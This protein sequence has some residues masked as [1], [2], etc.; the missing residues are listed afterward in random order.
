MKSLVFRD[1]LRILDTEVNS[2][3]KMYG[4]GERTRDKFFLDEGTYTSWAKDSENKYDEGVAGGNSYGVHPVYF[5]HTRGANPKYFGVFNLNA[6]MQNTEVK[7][8]GRLGAEVKHLLT[9]G[10][11]DLYVFIGS[12]PEL[13]VQMYHK[14]IGKPALPPYWGLGWHHGSYG[15]SNKSIW[16]DTAQKYV[17][18]SLILDG[19]WL[20]VNYM[21]R[22]RP[23]TIDETR[24]A[25]LNDTIVDVHNFG[26]KFVPIINPGIAVTINEDNNEESAY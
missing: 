2:A 17:Y 5:T 25:R 19:I 3:G 10:V 15:L 23:F 16:W 4:L 26:L 9:G 8:K 21:D 14:L 13:A 20:D 18:D 11:I 12:S 1:Y 6:N 7:F 24:F 22:F